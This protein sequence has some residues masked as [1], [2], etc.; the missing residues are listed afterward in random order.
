MEK[1]MAKVHKYKK[2]INYESGCTQK[3]YNVTEL[4]ARETVKIIA[5][6]LLNQTKNW[7]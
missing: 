5:Q 6:Y 3:I 4:L 7:H 2:S 1:G